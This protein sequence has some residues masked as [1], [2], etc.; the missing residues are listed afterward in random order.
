MTT[1]T[2]Q[3]TPVAPRRRGSSYG[4]VLDV[5]I[6]LA[7][8]AVAGLLGALLW[9]QVV[10]LP[11][12]T[13]VGDAASLSPVEL[14]KQVGIDA[15]FFVIALVAALVS[16]IV[17]LLC[18]RRDPLLMVVLVVVGGGLAAWLMVHLGRSLGPG[19]EVAA[20]RQVPDGGTAPT[21]LRLHAPGV[22]LVWPIASA[23]GALVYLWV[24]RPN[25][26]GPA[27]RSGREA[28]EGGRATETQE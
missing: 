13:R 9:S 5:V 12:A 28:R 20:L 8:Y 24:L 23:L 7:W 21:Q 1:T 11:E 19:D 18:R 25:D 10:S 17:L 27:H 26:P 3:A 4:P 22:E 6:T 16:A 15:W 2:A 14:T